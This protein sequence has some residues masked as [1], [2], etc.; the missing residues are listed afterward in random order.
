MADFEFLV[1]EKHWCHFTSGPEI[2]Y[3][4]AWFQASPTKQ[5]RTAFFCIISQRVMVI[6]YWRFRTTYRS[7]LQGSRI[8]KESW[9]S[10]YSVYVGKNVN[11]EKFLVVRCQS[12]VLMQVVIIFS[13]PSSFSFSLS[14]IPHYYVPFL[15]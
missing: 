7:H 1:R 5:M 6:S 3:G 8:R 9:L 13:S 12:I 2:N 14:F 10:K 4:H 15:T 11:G